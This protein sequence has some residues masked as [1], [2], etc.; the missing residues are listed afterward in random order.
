MSEVM[1]CGYCSHCCLQ[2]FL[3]ASN[4]SKCCS[5]LLCSSWLLALLK[6]C[7]CGLGGDTHS[8]LCP[9]LDVFSASARWQNLVCSGHCSSSR[10]LQDWPGLTLISRWTVGRWWK[11]IHRRLSDRQNISTIIYQQDVPDRPEM[12]RSREP[13]MVLF[14]RIICHTR[15]LLRPSMVTGHLWTPTATGLLCVS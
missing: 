9:G 3:S 5:K 6:Q 10:C 14:R 4:H 8:L 1:Y 13:R 11:S 7:N 2:T 15:W 12:N